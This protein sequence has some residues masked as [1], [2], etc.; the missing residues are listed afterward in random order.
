MAILFVARATWSRS[1]RPSTLRWALAHRL[2]HVMAEDRLPSQLGRRTAVHDPAAIE[3]VYV[4]D[5]LERPLDILLNNE[6]PDPAGGQ[7]R[8]RSEELINDARRQ[9]HGDFIDKYAER[10]W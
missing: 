7:C 8:Q 4:V 9:T 2:P 10:V 6:H 3:H 1:R 5:H